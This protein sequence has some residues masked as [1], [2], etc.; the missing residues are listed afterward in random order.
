[1]ARFFHQPISHDFSFSLV[2]AKSHGFGQLSLTRPSA[3]CKEFGN[4]LFV[5]ASSRPGK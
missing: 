4:V 5:G 2:V 3:E 1:M